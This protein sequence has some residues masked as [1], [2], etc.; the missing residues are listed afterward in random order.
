M[1]ICG[2]PD[3]EVVGGSKRGVGQLRG[4]HGQPAAAGAKGAHL[5]RHRVHNGIA[6]GI[7][8]MC[9]HVVIALCIGHKKT[10]NNRHLQS[11]RGPWRVRQILPYDYVLGYVMMK[12]T[13]PVRRQI[14]ADR[15]KERQDPETLGPMAYI[16]VVLGGTTR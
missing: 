15:H 8:V 14:G 1:T 2:K 16:A 3:G 12:T 11:I 10:D 6:I 9:L 4:L 13:H 7:P 5:N